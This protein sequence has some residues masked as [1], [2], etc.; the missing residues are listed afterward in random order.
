MQYHGS[1]PS[2]YPSNSSASVN[3]NTSTNIHVINF[4]SEKHF[5]LVGIEQRKLKLDTTVDRGREDLGAVILEEI[6]GNQ[7]E[8]TARPPQKIIN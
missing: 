7:S 6:W 1:F 3:T 8:T 2:K 4:I 5:G